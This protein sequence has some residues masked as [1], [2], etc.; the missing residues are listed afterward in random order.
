MHIKNSKLFLCLA[1][2]QHCKSFSVPLEHCHRYTLER[3][4]IVS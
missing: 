4:E 2:S 3:Q 1:A